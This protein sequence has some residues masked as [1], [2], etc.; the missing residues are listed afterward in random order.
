[1][2]ALRGV[3]SVTCAQPVWAEVLPKTLESRL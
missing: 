1:M 3:G 2:L